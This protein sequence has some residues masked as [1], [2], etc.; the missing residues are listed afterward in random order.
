VSRL[1]GKVCVVTGASTGIGAA[2]ARELA[3][4][5]GAVVG[6]ARRF[7]NTALAGPPVA[8]A[9]TEVKLDVSVEQDVDAL[10]GALGDIDILVNNAGVG[11]FAPL[12]R[13]ELAQLREML[14]VHIVGTFLCARA[15]LRTMKRN[16]RGHIINVISTAAVDTFAG[17]AGY[18]AAKIGQLGLT[19]VLREEARAY[20]VRVTALIPGAVDTPIWDDRPGFDRSKML[21][22]TD[23]AGTVV[24][25]VCRPAMAVDEILIRP[26]AGNL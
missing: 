15:A 10:C 3:E 17:C 6:V 1:E 21:L 4:Q 16:Q 12:E 8:G 24:D 19:R 22:P 13:T 20:D 5:G 7:E 26:P 2:V 18:T 23:I 11:Y 25:I 9:V 14:D